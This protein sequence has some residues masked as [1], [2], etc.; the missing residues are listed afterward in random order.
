LPECKKAE[1]N[2]TLAEFERSNTDSK[3]LSG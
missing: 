3:S 1:N 2:Q